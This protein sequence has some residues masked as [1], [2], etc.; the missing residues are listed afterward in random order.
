MDAARLILGL[1][2]FLVPGGLLARRARLGL[3]AVE[4]L[5]AAFAVSYTLLMLAN[6]VLFAFHLNIWWLI[7]MW[8]VL[9]L[10]LVV[11]HLHRRAAPAPAEPP[12]E[13]RRTRLGLWLALASIATLGI[14]VYVHGV[15]LG[16]EEEIDLIITRKLLENP[17]LEIDQVNYLRGLSATYLLV[18]LQLLR[19]MLS[20][21]T[22]I[23]PVVLHYRLGFIGPVIALAALYALVLEFGAGRFV[24]RIALT[25]AAA[26]AVFGSLSVSRP[27][28]LFS[29]GDTPMFVRGVAVIQLVYLPWLVAVVRAT[30]RDTVRR[31]PYAIAAALL[32]LAALFTHGVNGAYYLI[33]LG[34][35]LVAVGVSRL[36]ER[37]V[38]IRHASTTVAISLVVIGVF[39]VVLYKWAF[40]TLIPGGEAGAVRTRAE[41]GAILSRL[42]ADP[43]SALTE[44]PPP[45]TF[46]E[47]FNTRGTTFG[48]IDSL[49]MARLTPVVAIAFLVSPLLWLWRTGASAA[50][51]AAAPVVLPIIARLP[52]LLVPLVYV[53]PSLLSSAYYHLAAP[54]VAALLAATAR[55]ATTLTT[56]T[57]RRPQRGVRIAVTAALVIGF[58]A[59]GV[60][61]GGTGA[62]FVAAI[63]THRD[64]ALMTFAGVAVVA[65]L[66]GWLLR[67]A[68]GEEHV[69]RPAVMA[70]DGA[71]AGV[72]TAAL[73]LPLFLA[74]E[75]RA[76]RLATAAWDKFHAPPA[77]GEYA[78]YAENMVGLHARQTRFPQGLFEALMFVRAQLPP[79]ATF[80]A[81]P[82]VIRAIPLITNHYITHSG[83][84]FDFVERYFMRYYRPNE[85]GG[86]PY[87]A[88]DPL[89]R[90]DRALDDAAARTASEMVHAFKVD[91]VLVTPAFA[92]Y[93]AELLARAGRHGAFTT[94]LLYSESGYSVIRIIP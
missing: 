93:T 9:T 48:H 21:V 69:T 58:L 30:R 7:G 33:V 4:Q 62:A 86:S 61:L 3:D 92:D 79:G 52:L 64:Q 39:S 68:A 63:K 66:A 56:L 83:V 43:V 91:Y 89:F 23:D 45:A 40:D 87:I 15:L 85:G 31:S 53:N 19:A 71:W 65:A 47:Y 24:A 27:P 84:P 37:P 26:W 14:A 90:A 35:V 2:F 75:G 60:W 12:R 6:I 36:S 51:V 77:A 54:A 34:L 74:P 17:R 50:A 78:R 46:Y 5:A 22:Q 72:L 11:P 76:P 41:V 82:D 80:D 29:L 38:S 59:V 42:F 10:A 81:D 70:G 8:V 18:P 1:L 94:E 57:A 20:A 67:R 88:L 73:L 13:D 55:L 32:F 25:A 49:F 44:L 28:L 16:G